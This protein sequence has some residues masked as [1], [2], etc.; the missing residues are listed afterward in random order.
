MP[1]TNDSLAILKLSRVMA[2]LSRRQDQWMSLHGVSFKEFQVM[3]ALQC[4]PG[5]SL[6][7]IELAEQV[8]LSASG[9]TR[10]LNP[11]E[12]IGLL[13]KEEGARDARVSLVKMTPAGQ[14]MYQDAQAT[15][16]LQART[17]L[18]TFSDQQKQALTLLSTVVL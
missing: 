11:M 18:K 9:V 5:G 16:N 15:L 17:L 2:K 6:K 8:E 7:R 4:A 12:K 14:A 13:T 10:L 3:H 1:L